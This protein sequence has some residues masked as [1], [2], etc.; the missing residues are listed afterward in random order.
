MDAK[1]H[2]IV[3][4]DSLPSDHGSAVTRLVEDI[5]TYASAY[6]PAPLVTYRR[7]QSSSELIMALSDCADRASSG[8]F[9]LLHFECHGS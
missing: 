8:V 2:E 4:L 3:V 1:F 9:P 7:V 5:E 6:P